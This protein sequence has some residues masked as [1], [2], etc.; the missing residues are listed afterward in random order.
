MTLQQHLHVLST[1]KL[2]RIHETIV[3]A[4]IVFELGGNYKKVF[5]ALR[6]QSTGREKKIY[7]A[8][9]KSNRDEARRFI[10]AITDN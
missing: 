1:E 6:A 4:G 2:K 8:L 9:A 7:S 10:D 3:D 5:K